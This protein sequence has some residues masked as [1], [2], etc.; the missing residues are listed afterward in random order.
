MPSALSHDLAV[1]GLGASAGGIAALQRFFEQ[2]PGR[3]G[4]AFVVVLHLSPTHESTLDQILRKCTSMPVHQVKGPTPVLADNV[5]LIPPSSGLAMVDG[6][7]RLV[8]LPRADGHPASIDLLFRTM[9]TA[10]GERAICVVLSGSGSDG[11]LGIARVKE[12]GGVTIAQSPADAEFDSMPR[13]AIATGQVDIVLAAAEIPQRLIEIW[14]NARRIRLPEPPRGLAVLSTADRETAAATDALEAIMAW[15]HERTGHDFLHY[16]RATVLRRIERRMQ[17]NAVP[18]IPDYLALL[19]RDADETPALLQDMLISVTNFFRDRDAF[20]GLERQLERLHAARPAD[21]PVR[22]WVAGCATGEEAYSVAMLLCDEFAREPAVHDIQVFA[23]DIDQR[24]IEFARH[25]VYPEAVAADVPPHQLRR[26]L[27]RDESGYR[28]VR[29]VRDKVT[30]STHNLLR[31][32]PFTRLDLV[33][34]RNVLIYLDRT[35]QMKVLR[36][37]HYALRPGGLLMLGSAETTDAADG[38]FEVIDKRLRL[39][40]AV[41]H[42]A[43]RRDEVPQVAT[44]AIASRPAFPSSARID[45]TPVEDLHHRLH[46]RLAAPSILVDAGFNV[47]N[48]HHRAAAYLRHVGG[49]PTNQLLTLIRPEL[50][51]ALRATLKRALQG[52]AVVEAP[53]VRLDRRLGHRF[54]RMVARPVLGTGGTEAVAHLLISFDELEA[55]LASDDGDNSRDAIVAALEQELERVRAE[56]ANGSVQSAHATE[57]LRASNEELQAVNEELRSTTEEL[58]TSTEEL[59]S[60]NEELLTVNQELRAGIDETAKLNDDLRNLMAST[61]I[62]IL[63]LDRDLS[64]KRFTP[65]ATSIFSLIAGDVGRS[66]RDI[67]HRLQYESLWQDL[68]S[69]MHTL[70]HIEREVRTNDGRWFL[71]RLLP[72]RAGEDRIDGVVMSLVDV[73]THHEVQERL[74]ASERYVRLVGQSAQ[75]YAMLAMDLDGVITWWAQ[76]A[77]RLF[78]YEADEI[79][80]RN[81]EVLFTPEDRAAGVPKAEMQTARIHGRADDDRW[82]MRKDGSAF[83]CGGVLT[84]LEDGELIGFAKIARD[85]TQSRLTEAERLARLEVERDARL[86][87][88]EAS[89]LK[90]EFIAVMAHELKNPLHLIRIHTDLMLY[91]PETRNL[92]TVHRYVSAI[93]RAVGSQ[94]RIIEDLLDWSRLRMGKLTLRCEPIDLRTIVERLAVACRTDAQ[95]KGVEL[96]IEAAQ[97]LMIEGDPVRVEQIIWNVVNN[98]IKFTPAGGRVRIDARA[99]DGRAVL[100]VEDSGAGIEPAFLPNV[101]DM[102][103]QGQSDD[104]RGKG[105]L[106]IGLALVKRLADLH[107]A[108][109]DLHSEGPGHG[110][111][112]TASFPLIEHAAPGETAPVVAGRLD[113]LRVLVIGADREARAA[114]E[115]LL[116]LAGAVVTSAES[117][118]HAAALANASSVDILLVDLAASDAERNPGSIVERIRAQPGLATLPIVAISGRNIE[119][120]AEMVGIGGVEALVAKPADLEA[121]VNALR[122]FAAADR[123]L[124]SA[125]A[126]H[127]TRRSQ[128]P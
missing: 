125:P 2:V 16:K 23:S 70:Q 45:V 41:A 86:R 75:D 42:Q 8:E 127:A 82:M 123:A 85:L 68:D 117:P 34:C 5:Y 36:T 84:K 94:V 57:D 44:A 71:A 80:G 102:F 9:A 77:H 72:Y 116:P 105:G 120:D 69:V 15:L 108:E 91:S 4:M 20:E 32:P 122:R 64:I 115:S 13:N 109:V 95:A 14:G 21:L 104:L 59:Q 49:A 98:A 52:K 55:T 99:R 73:T 58:E 119:R 33:C 35:A 65:M 79:L 107:G 66:L 61:D 38:L 29:N 6:Y 31:D 128:L 121:L 30:F 76:G 54:V 11:S 17:V 63:F 1:V 25:G 39:F 53:L 40:R 124:G 96:G 112:F 60:T 26:H 3:T 50:R 114:L 88:E 10:H 37:F 46:E 93:H 47:L 97:E 89:G 101:F 19:H 67:T 78:G 81:V 43:D 7:L 27:V 92:P 22:A 12:L 48:V 87:L 126:P 103:R 110:C 74:R 113:G 106:G 28:I 118:T 18:T 51:P 111:V 100:R 24:A 62:A 90:D 83:F 56:L